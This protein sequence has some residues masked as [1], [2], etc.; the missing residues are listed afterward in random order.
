MAV[1]EQAKSKS[2]VRKFYEIHYDLFAE[3]EAI[4][5]GQ[6]ADN[7]LPVRGLIYEPWNSIK[8]YLKP[9]GIV[10]SQESG[11]VTKEPMTEMDILDIMDKLYK[12]YPILDS[13]IPGKNDIYTK[14]FYITEI[15]KSHKYIQNGKFQNMHFDPLEKTS[16]KLISYDCDTI[17]MKANGIDP[18]YFYTKVNDYLSGNNH[19]A[20]HHDQR[21]VHMTKKHMNT[22]DAAN[23]LNNLCNKIPEFG[24]YCK[25]CTIT[26]V[27]E[28]TDY[29]AYREEKKIANPNY[30]PEYVAIPYIQNN[31]KMNL[32]VFLTYNTGVK[33]E[34]Y[35]QYKAKDGTVDSED[36]RHA[37]KTARK[38]LERNDFEKV[39]N[40]LYKTTKDIPVNDLIKS[41]DT[42]YNRK[43]NNGDSAFKH[44]MTDLTFY[45]KKSDYESAQR[46]MQRMNAADK[47]LEDIT[48]ASDGNF[49]NKDI[50]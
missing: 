28:N 46:Q 8:E 49:E 17:T 23:L 30:W 9:Y 18:G 41:F 21:S 34:I 27:I 22:C 12:R 47:L 40:G 1:N 31:N 25:D 10:K 6:I 50:K 19:S 2:D 33:S 15:G 37:R 5:K 7:G 11:L 44:S 13:K 36:C 32:P 39:T 48:F 42:S 24:K 20:T 35:V 26:D 43:V 3:A 16:Q 29:L 4:Y 38:I 45:I 14:S